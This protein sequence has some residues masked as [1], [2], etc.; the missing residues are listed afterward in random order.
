[1]ATKR[2]IRKHTKKEGMNQ[3]NFIPTYIRS[4]EG[5]R[6]GCCERDDER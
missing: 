6:A 1:M 3:A 4:E 5:D 2:K